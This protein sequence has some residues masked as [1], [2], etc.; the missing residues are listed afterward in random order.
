[1]FK[2]IY[3]NQQL[4]QLRSKPLSAE[5]KL[6]KEAND[7]LNES[8]RSDKNILKNL[9]RYNKSFGLLNESLLNPDQ[10]YHTRELKELAIHYRLKFLDSSYYKSEIPIDTI[11]SIRKLNRAFNIDLKH[12]KI[13]APDISFT[14][15]NAD[16]CSLIFAETNQGN[17]YFIDYWGNGLKWY[18]RYMYWPLQ[19]FENLI[20][21]V[22]I[23]T[24]LLTLCLPT[25]LITLDNKAEYWSGYRAAAFFHLLIFNL[26][27]TVYFTFT[28]AKNFSSAIWNQYKDFG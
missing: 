27:V 11:E 6:L 8:T 22:F 23:I 17:Y 20:S 10:I 18:R 1:M 24:L 3:L 4:L 13:L 7:L 9:S 5:E 12:F 2:Q 15:E 26:G 19:K 21:V 14:K 28:F 16:L 25:G